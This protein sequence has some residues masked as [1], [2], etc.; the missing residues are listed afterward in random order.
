MNYRSFILVCFLLSLSSLAAEDYTS[1]KQKG[2]YDEIL[3]C[4]VN[5]EG[6]CE[7]EFVEEVLELCKDYEVPPPQVSEPSALRVW[8]TKWGIALFYTVHDAKNWVSRKLFGTQESS[9]E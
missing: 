4:I 7:K 2:E 3:Q 9:E 6:V 1:D 5:S 8:A